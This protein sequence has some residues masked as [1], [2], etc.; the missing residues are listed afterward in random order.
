LG[1]GVENP[2]KIRFITDDIQSEAYAMLVQDQL[3]RE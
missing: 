2:E 1:L 3:F